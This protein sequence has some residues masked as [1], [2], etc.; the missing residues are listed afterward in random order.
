[1]TEKDEFNAI[2]DACL[3]KGG[4]LLLEQVQEH[5]TASDTISVYPATSEAMFTRL[6]YVQALEWISGL[7]QQYKDTEYQGDIQD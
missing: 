3:S 1:M 6:G 5:K 4:A 7:M 2:K